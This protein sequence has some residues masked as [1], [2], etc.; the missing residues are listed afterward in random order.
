MNDQK[1]CSKFDEVISRMLEN[2]LKGTPKRKLEVMGDLIHDFVK[3]RFDL[4]E[5]RKQSPAPTLN[6]PQ[7]EISRLRNN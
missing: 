7:K 1:A 4:V 5:P 6:R 3:G 2:T